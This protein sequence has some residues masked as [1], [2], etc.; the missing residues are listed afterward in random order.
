MNPTREPRT[1]LQLGACQSRMPR[2]D[3][4]A[5]HDTPRPSDRGATS[6]PLCFEEREDYEWC[7]TTATMPLEAT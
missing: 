3:N 5:I 1:C 2:C 4:C 7:D 6:L